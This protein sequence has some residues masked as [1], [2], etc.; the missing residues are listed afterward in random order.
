MKQSIKIA[1]LLLLVVSLFTVS[2][3][4]TKKAGGCG[5][6]ARQGMVGF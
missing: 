4:S 1:A 2:C 3:S 5:C 6:P